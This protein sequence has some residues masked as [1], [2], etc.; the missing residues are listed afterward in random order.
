M[1]VWRTSQQTVLW[2]LFDRL[3]TVQLKGQLQTRR[4]FGS[5]AQ[6]HNPS[7]VPEPGHL[8]PS[9]LCPYVTLASQKFHSSLRCC[10][11][12][13]ASSFGKQGACISLQRCLTGM[14]AQTSCRR[15]STVHGTCVLQ[16]VRREENLLSL[17]RSF[18]SSSGKIFPLPEQHLKSILPAQRWKFLFKSHTFLARTLPLICAISCPYVES[19]CQWCWRMQD[20]VHFPLAVPSGYAAACW[21]R[22]ANRE[23]RAEP[24]LSAAGIFFPKSAC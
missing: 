5:K 15:L 11:F 9:S 6:Q 13:W 14:R 2:E 18:F 17:C 23:F 8:P 21:A 7:T 3:G 10:C 20:K 19:A 12:I 1:I 16:T 22:K 24:G 4:V